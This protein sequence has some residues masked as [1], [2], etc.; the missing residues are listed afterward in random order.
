M[1][2][3]FFIL[4]TA[5]I[6]FGCQESNSVDPISD[7]SDQLNKVEEDL[8]KEPL[9]NGYSKAKKVECNYDFIPSA[10]CGGMLCGCSFEYQYDEAIINGETRRYLKDVQFWA[11]STMK[12]GKQTIQTCN[13]YNLNKTERVGIND[14]ILGGEAWGTFQVKVATGDCLFDIYESSDILFEGKFSGVIKGKV[15]NVKMFAKGQ[16]Q[17]TGRNF[18]AKEVQVC[19]ENNRKIN[20]ISSVIK[21]EVSPVIKVEE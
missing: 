6:F 9:L 12:I 3:L 11:P 17:M 5:V 10:Q 20:C 21:G 1:K 4:L 7:Y 18:V 13:I 8:F 16:N 15:T 2:Q 14:K 19:Y